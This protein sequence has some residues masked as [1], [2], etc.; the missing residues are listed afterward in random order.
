VTAEEGTLRIEDPGA[1]E[2]RATV[3]HMF[4][5]EE[6]LSAFYELVREDDLAW[7]AL[8]AGRML[9]A[10]TVFEDVVRTTCTLIRRLSPRISAV[11]VEQEHAGPDGGTLP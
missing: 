3:A 8:G 4:R 2:L 11:S 10:P 5:L 6:D 1:D 9:H 7:C